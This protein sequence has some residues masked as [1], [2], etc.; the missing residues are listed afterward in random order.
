MHFMQALSPAFHIPERAIKIE[1]GFPQGVP[2][3]VKQGVPTDPRSD[4]ITMTNELR[5]KVRSI[6]PGVMVAYI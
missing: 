1:Y 3:S 6:G 5:P 2:D 4:S